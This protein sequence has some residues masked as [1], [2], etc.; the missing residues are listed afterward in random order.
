MIKACERLRMEVCAHAR[1]SVCVPVC[2][3]IHT[4]MY[5]GALSWDC[6]L[7]QMSLA[8]IEEATMLYILKGKEVYV[9]FKKK[10][11]APLQ[12]IW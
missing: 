12:M 10:R 9:Y 11:F 2:V 3:S 1:V 5:G 6:D 7:E 8:E 4:H